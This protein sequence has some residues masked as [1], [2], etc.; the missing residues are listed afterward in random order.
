M[1]MSSLPAPLA[2]Q[3]VVRLRF[4]DLPDAI[5]GVHEPQ[6]LADVPERQPYSAGFRVKSLF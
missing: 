5:P 3:P 2:S 6:K 4:Q 1:L